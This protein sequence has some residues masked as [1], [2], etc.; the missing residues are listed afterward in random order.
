MH[1]LLLATSNQYK[2]REFVALLS[3]EFAICD[4]NAYPG[5]VKGIESGVTFEENA[6]AKA[7][8]ASK[9]ISDL[10]VADDSGLEVDALKGA[11]GI[12]SARYA[13]EGASDRANVEKLLRELAQ[14][15]VTESR[16]A[17]FRCVLAA[18]RDGKLLGTF[19]GTVE[20]V[21]SAQAAGTSGFGY[22]PIF[23]PKGFNR[24]FAEL[25]PATKN[26]ISH[27]AR[28]VEALRKRLAQLR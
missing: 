22:D 24:T 13:G 2:T 12:F 28:A 3:D 4:L 15:A 1:Q 14:I 16:S 6:A 10:V 27:R 7:L 23:V 11:P 26:K 20:G 17:R 18:A 19:E 25:S 8:V 5:F 9:Q 21:I